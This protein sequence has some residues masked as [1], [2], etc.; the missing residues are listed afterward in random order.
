MNINIPSAPP[1]EPVV[2]TPE[3]MIRRPTKR[4]RRGALGVPGPQDPLAGARSLLQRAIDYVE[5]VRA[6]RR[7]AAEITAARSYR[8]LARQILSEFRDHPQGVR[9]TVCSVGAEPSSSEALLLM[10]HFLHDESGGKVLLVDDTH[11]GDTLGS[12]LDVGTG[13]GMLDTFEGL[14]KSAADL[15]RP[16]P[17]RGVFVLPMGQTP[18]EWLSPAQLRKVPEVLEGLT[19]HFAFV[20]VQQSE[21]LDDRRHRYFAKGSDVSLLLVQEGATS[22]DD[23]SLYRHAMAD[24]EVGAV[25]VVLCCTN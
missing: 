11:A 21:I 4:K 8:N 25:R 12:R 3:A 10:A 22:V 24:A 20:L 19:E 1:A 13:P 17:Q 14:D 23:I 2:E 16:T 15:V 9:I 5:K 7:R 18:I 6:D